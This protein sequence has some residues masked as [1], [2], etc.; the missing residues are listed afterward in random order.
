ME[1]PLTGEI[2][3]APLDCSTL[4]ETQLENIL[5]MWMEVK[6]GI[7]ETWF[8]IWIHKKRRFELSPP[9]FGTIS[10]QHLFSISFLWVVSQV[11]TD[12]VALEKYLSHLPKLCILANLFNNKI[13]L[14]PP[15]FG[16]TPPQL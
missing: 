15:P 10:K 12:I 2:G 9:P 3:F 14:S 1:P 16:T 8:K 7:F 6:T 13:G 11:V 5:S 4:Q